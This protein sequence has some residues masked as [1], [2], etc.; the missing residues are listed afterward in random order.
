M[1][2]VTSGSSIWTDN[3]AGSPRKP[4]PTLSSF[5]GVREQEEA[6]DPQAVY[7]SYNTTQKVPTVSRFTL[8][9]V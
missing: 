5:D 7:E 1:G 9:L 6:E 8:K 2:N 3:Y 4:N